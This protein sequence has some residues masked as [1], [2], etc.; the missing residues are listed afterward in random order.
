MTHVLDTQSL[1]TPDT[2]EDTIAARFERQVSEFPDRL[3]LVTDEVSLTYRELDLKA[4]RIAGA[5]ASLLPT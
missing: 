3:A 4:S 1:R 5:L 2:S